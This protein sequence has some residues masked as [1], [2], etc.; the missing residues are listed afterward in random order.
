M[1]G[2]GGAFSSSSGPDLS[3]ASGI[4]D[5]HRPQPSLSTRPFVCLPLVGD[6]V[7]AASSGHIRLSPPLCMPS[8][9]GRRHPRREIGVLSLGSAPL[10]AFLSREAPSLARFSLSLLQRSH[11]RKAHK[12]ATAG[13]SP[14][15]RHCVSRLFA[16]FF[17]E[18]RRQDAGASSMDGFMRLPEEGSKET[19]RSKRGEIE[20]RRDRSAARSKRG[21]IEAR[22]DRSAARSKRGEI[23][24]R[25]DRSA[26]R[27]KRRLP[28]D[29]SS[30]G[31]SEATRLM[32]PCFPGGPSVRHAA[33]GRVISY[34][35]TE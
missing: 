2:G 1:N 31:M 32:R 7:R 24:A 18:Y 14:G 21:E 29:Q 13:A 33:V 17:W 16:P 3:P 23:E 11:E 4:P 27:S 6:A 19:A 12:G 15:G 25:R 30:S 5:A 28:G 26:A 35:P 8:S 20:A 34:S 9:R 10:C 22:R